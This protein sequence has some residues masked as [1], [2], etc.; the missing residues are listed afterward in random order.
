M[1]RL[2]VGIFF[3]SAKIITP[4]VKTKFDFL[5]VFTLLTFLSYAAMDSS[6]PAQSTRRTFVLSRNG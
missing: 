2:D 4:G 1:E 3:G 5:P 6:S